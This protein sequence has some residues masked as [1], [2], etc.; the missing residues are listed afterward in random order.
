MGYFTEWGNS[1]YPASTRKGEKAKGRPSDLISNIQFQ[2]FQIF[3]SKVSGVKS[4]ILL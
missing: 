4:A 2:Q 3:I 1:P